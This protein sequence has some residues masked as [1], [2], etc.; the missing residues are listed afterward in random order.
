MNLLK[1]LIDPTPGSE[2]PL[3]WAF[4]I[5]FLLFFLGSFQL[6]KLFPKSLSHA[7]QN[8]VFGGTP[9]RLREF[10]ALG[11]LWTFF[12]DQNV[13]YLGM[14]LWPLVLAF[15]ALAYTASIFKNY[16]ST[17]ELMAHGATKSKPQVD[18]YKPRKKKKR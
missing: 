5:I 3:F 7:M 18:P 16:R 17:L 1:Q 9:A 8:Y 13:P 6:K 14:S 4:A 11:L 10:A 2:F 12:R 15:G